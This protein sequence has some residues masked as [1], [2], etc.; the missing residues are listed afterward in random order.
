MKHNGLSVV[1]CLVLWC[2]MSSQ[3][4]AAV[5]VMPKSQEHWT[6]FD[7]SVD[8]SAKNPDWGIVTMSDHPAF[9]GV[10]HMDNYKL[11]KKNP[12]IM[13]VHDGL[14]KNDY[15]IANWC[16]SDKYYHFWINDKPA[17]NYLVMRDNKNVILKQYNIITKP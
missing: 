17:R 2:L 12:K 15:Q 4:F 5:Q 16:V 6:C 8:F 1:L 9:R 11:D 7:Y 13:Y 14:Y 10:S 3:A